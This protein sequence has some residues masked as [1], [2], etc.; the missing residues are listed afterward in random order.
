[1]AAY[2]SRDLKL[3]EVVVSIAEGRIRL[4]EF[5]RNFNWVISLRRALLDSIQKGYPVGTLLLLEVGDAEESP[6]GERLFSGA[7]P[8]TK[9][10]E[11]LVLD[12]QQRLSTCFAALS[13]TTERMFCI[14]LSALFDNTGGK[15]RQPVDFGDFIVVRNRPTHVQNLLYN[16]NLLPFEFLTDRDALREKLATFRANLMKNPGTEE[17]GKF[18]ETYLEGYVDVFFD[19]RFPAV[20]LP[21]DL[22]VEAVANVFTQINTSGLKLSAFDLCVA[23]LYK[24]GVNLHELW[25]T[26]RQTDEVSAFDQ[27]GTNLLQTVALLTGKPPKKAALVKN[28]TEADINSYWHE[29][30]GGLKSAGALLSSIGIP[31]RAAVPYDALVPPLAAALARTPEPKT[32]PDREALRRK[33][34]RWVQ[35]SAFLQLYNEGTDVKQAAHYPMVLA[36]FGGGDDPSFLSDTVVWQVSWDHLSR[37]GARYRA[38]VA[39]LNEAAPRDLIQTDKHLGLGLPD[40]TLAQL[41]HIFPRAYLRDLGYDPKQIELALNITFL[42]ADSN[43]FISNRAP[44]VYIE[45]RIQHLEKL[46]IARDVATSNLKAV[47]ADHLV[48]EAAW[49]AL[50]DD[51]YEAFVTARGE[52]VRNRLAALGVAVVAAR[53]DDAEAEAEPDD[54]DGQASDVPEV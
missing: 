16:K 13:P 42:T 28:I 19:Y 6:F 33:V 44:S 31:D 23:T 53:P 29:A 24:K 39:F 36:W 26:A 52:A 27:D 32:P 11:L 40:R 48:N 25:A 49:D 7:P 45:D 4:P 30:V 34:G 12:G 46:G 9:P 1:M 38:I 51:D 2:Q 43:N 37:S 41:H 54:D 18:V 14:D 10:A 5:Q 35:Q 15:P 47:L 50:V 22:D 20:V 3:Q 8:P 17:F 21:S